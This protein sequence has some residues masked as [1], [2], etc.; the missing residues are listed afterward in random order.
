MVQW[1]NSGSGNERCCQ[2]SF[3]CCVADK[4]AGPGGLPWLRRFFF[5]C[6][7]QLCKA[8][9]SLRKKR[10]DGASPQYLE[11]DEHEDQRADGLREN[12]AQ[13]D[14]GVRP[15]GFLPCVVVQRRRTPRINQMLSRIAGIQEWDE[16]QRREPFFPSRMGLLGEEG[17][18][19]CRVSLLSSALALSA[20]TRSAKYTLRSD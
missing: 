15:L 3:L 11:D 4:V 13:Q 6:P 1:F 5:G 19:V 2:G 9:C 8:I 18:F 10:G 12:E 16:V 20:A 7:V 17:D 14:L